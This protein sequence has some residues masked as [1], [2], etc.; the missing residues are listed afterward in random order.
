[1]NL[2]YNPASANIDYE[3]ADLLITKGDKDAGIARLR[4]ILV[5]NPNDR[6]AR[7]RLTQLGVQP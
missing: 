5:K 6:R 1:M 4:A 3:I 7:T 2:E